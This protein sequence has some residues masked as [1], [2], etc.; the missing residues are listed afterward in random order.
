MPY[1]HKYSIIILYEP[2]KKAYLKEKSE[3]D[4]TFFTS[5]R[6]SSPEKEN[7][8]LN[9]LPPCRSKPVKAE[10]VFGQVWN[11]MG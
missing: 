6:G 1:F 4:L 9:H 10:F 2:D 7:F 11:D 5:E 8:V 3:T